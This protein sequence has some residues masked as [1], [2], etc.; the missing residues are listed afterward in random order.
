VSTDDFEARRLVP[1]NLLAPAAAAGTRGLI[2]ATCSIFTRGCLSAR[3]IERQK[4]GGS[5]TALPIN[6][7]R[8]PATFPAYIP[9]NVISITDGQIYLETDLFNQGVR[10]AVNVVSR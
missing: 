9:T 5:L 7:K 1:R 4:R 8:K 2:Q 6:W 10:P 3:Q